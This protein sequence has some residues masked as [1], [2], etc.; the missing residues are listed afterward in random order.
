MAHIEVVVTGDKHWIKKTAAVQG[1]IGDIAVKPAFKELGDKFMDTLREL[2]GANI[3]VSRGER[4]KHGYTGS[5]L[6]GIKSNITKEELTI[7]ESNPKGGEQ[8]REGTGPGS[9]V[10]QGDVVKWAMNKLGVSEREAFA[11][12]RSVSK[13][14]IGYVGGDSPLVDEHPAG[15]GYFAYPEWIVTIKNKTDVEDAAED[16]GAFIVS[17]LET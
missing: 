16:M 12:G 13:H 5:Y 15:L 1:N 10:V 9:G 3:G 7:A 6:S 14:G 17:Y 2:F 4:F 8:I 11:I